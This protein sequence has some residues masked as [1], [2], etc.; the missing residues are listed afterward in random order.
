MNPNCG[1]INSTNLNFCLASSK[2]L[3]YKFKMNVSNS[4]T[5]A[6]FNNAQNKTQLTHARIKC[7]LKDSSC[8]TPLSYIFSL[9]VLSSNK[10]S[11]SNNNIPSHKK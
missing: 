11:S 5:Q 6:L 9:T 1:L 2:T 7:A 8:G 3:V 10:S 4:A